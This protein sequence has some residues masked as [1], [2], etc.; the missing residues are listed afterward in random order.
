MVFQDYALYP[1]MNVRKN[2]E[3]G[4][5]SRGVPREAARARARETAEL[6][7]LGEK[8]GRKPAQLSGG[9]RQRVAL[10]RAMIRDPRAYLMDEPL[11]NL[12]ASLRQRMRGELIDFH[13]KT[14][15]TILFVTHDQI[16]AMTM[17]ERIAIMNNGVFEQI[18][19][20]IEVYDR[21]ASLFV[22]QFLGSPQMNLVGGKARADGGTA[23]VEAG[24]LCFELPAGALAGATGEV[25]V[26][27]RPEAVRVRAK[28][29][30]DGDGEPGAG[31][32][33]AAGAAGVATAERRVDFIEH[34]GSDMLVHLKGDDGS[35]LVA[36]VPREAVR[37][38]TEKVEIRIAASRIHVFDPATGRALAHGADFAAGTD[39]GAAG[40]VDPADGG[41]ELGAPDD[42]GAAP[43]GAEASSPSLAGG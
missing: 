38:S 1:H 30:D 10:G 37:P 33:A 18:G 17:G 21:P 5:R 4:L 40:A 43:V 23:T 31:F 27:F 19:D 11:S 29:G 15:G 14:G 25:Q 39:D 41:R 13:R 12:D 16:E 3:F 20:A 24:D 34:L 36:R 42:G 28:D 7:G 6:L 26:G 35:E 32:V 2:L 8:L 22:A 9:E